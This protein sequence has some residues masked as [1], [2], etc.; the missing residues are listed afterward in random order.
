MTESIST[1]AIHDLLSQKRSIAIIWDV[2]D[3]QS[4]RP[5]LDADQAWHVLQK[6]ERSHDCEWGMT[7]DYIESV[8]DCLYPTPD[9][10]IEI[11]AVPHD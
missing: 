11:A 10:A 5:N 4:V 6:C 7:W 1:T 3:V 8:A 9:D 2:E